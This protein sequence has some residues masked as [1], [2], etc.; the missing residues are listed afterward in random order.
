MIIIF[1]DY[2]LQ[3]P[4]LGEIESILYTRA[5]DEKVI[6]LFAD[7]PRQNPKFAAYLLDVYATRFPQDSV[8]FCV[9]DPGVG[10]ENNMPVMCHVDGRWFVGPNNGIFDLL[11]RHSE[12]SVCHNITWKPEKLSH[13]FHGRDLYAP[14]CACLAKGE[15][16]ESEIFLFKDNNNWPDNLAEIIYFDGFGN[17]MTGLKADTL[18]HVSSIVI[19]GR[20]LCKAS[21]F[22]DVPVNEPFWYENSVGLIELAVNQGNAQQVLN[23]Q[24]GHQFTYN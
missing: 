5:M 10:N 21:T 8:F 17:A 23:L 6:T 24:L 15:K 16:L 9:V 11:I 4:Y 7:L 2:G 14:V 20:N 3:G 18:T 22:S 19:N 1:T 13:T 12:K